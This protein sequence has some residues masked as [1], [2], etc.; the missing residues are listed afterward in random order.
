[1]VRETKIPPARVY[2]QSRSSNIAGHYGALYVPSRTTLPA[3]KNPTAQSGKKGQTSP[4]GEL[5]EGSPGLDFFHRT[6][7]PGDFFSSVVLCSSPE[8]FISR[9]AAAR[10]AT[11]TLSL[12]NQIIVVVGLRLELGVLESWG[13]IERS[14]VEIHRPVGRVPGFPP[15]R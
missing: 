7:S 1:M 15:C 11:R 9:R 8:L 6:K 2:I 12:R 10:I 5:Q 13:R 3:V 14:Y 4:H